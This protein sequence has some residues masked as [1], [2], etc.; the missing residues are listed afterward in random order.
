MDRRQFGLFGAILTTGLITLSASAGEDLAAPIGGNPD[1][2]LNVVVFL[3]YNC[4]YCKFA[5][6]ELARFVVGDGGV[7]LTYRDW[8]IL[9]EASIYGA[10]IALAATYQGQY[11]TAHR[12]L[13][14][15]PGRRNPADRMRAA[16]QAAGLDIGR[17]DVDAVTHGAAIQARL[18]DNAAEAVKLALNAV[19]TILVGGMRVL[20]GFDVEN[21]QDYV[22]RARNGRHT[23]APIEGPQ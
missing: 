16:M 2:D 7:R 17:L 21:F 1:G 22:A 19:P 18:A 13:M 10:R 9:G 5:N 23:V 6:P 8:P 12:V 20:G 15:V 14:A 11:E 3:D 4:P